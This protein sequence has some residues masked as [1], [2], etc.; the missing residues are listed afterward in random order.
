MEGYVGLYYTI[1]RNNDEHVPAIA[2]D[3]DGNVP[4]L[5]TTNNGA[6]QYAYFR[7]DGVK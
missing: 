3:F 4:D 2:I 6:Y 7:P 5:P 1:G